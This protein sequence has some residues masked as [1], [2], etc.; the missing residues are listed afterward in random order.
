VTTKINE[1]KSGFERVATPDKY[2]ICYVYDGEYPWDI[3]VEKICKSI[4]NGGKKVIVFSRNRFR[5]KRYDVSDQLRIFRLPHVKIEFLNRW[6]NSSVFL[7]PFWFFSIY[8]LVKE[9]NI[10]LI[11]VRDLPISLSAILVSKLAKIPVIFDMAEPYPETLRD[12]WQYDRNRNSLYFLFRNPYM[13]EIVERLAVL[14]SDH[15]LVVS[16]ESKARLEQRL[17]VKRKV[18]IVGNTPSRSQFYPRNPTYPGSLSKIRGKKVVLFVGNLFVDRGLILA[19]RAIARLAGRNPDIRFLIVGEGEERPYIEKEI[20]EL[21]LQEVVTLEGWVDH[22]LLPEYIASSSL[23]ILPFLPSPHM[24]IT[25]PN[26]LFDFMAMGIPVI[27]SDVRPM[28]R[29]IEKEKVGLLFRAGDEISCANAIQRLISDTG[30]A[31]QI[32]ENCLMA[33]RERYNWDIDEKI[34][35]NIVETLIK[36]GGSGD[37]S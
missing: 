13:A 19:T 30:M 27:A 15:T 28:R 24:D 2:T 25:L 9:T 11:I 20:K 37:H 12:M 21:G 31:T 18:S 32:A 16:K 23:G 36:N 33:A 35:L 1:S 34:L 22:R 10:E 6:I 8:S 26:K 17:N 7:N 14:N 3:R 4:S 5:K 29:I